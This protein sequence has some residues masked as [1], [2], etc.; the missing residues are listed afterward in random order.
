VANHTPVNT[1]FVEIE[2]PGTKY[3]HGLTAEGCYIVEGDTVILTD[4]AGRPATDDE[5]KH[6]EEKLAA[7]L[8]LPKRLRL[9]LTGKGRASERA[10]QG[11]DPVSENQSY[12]VSSLIRLEPQ[13]FLGEEKSP[14]V[15][16]GTGASGSWMPPPR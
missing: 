8:G 15:L 11:H 10:R 6:Y 1:V 12:L 14:G 5:G 13:F 3:P 4:R 9:A 16:G 7:Q 2:R